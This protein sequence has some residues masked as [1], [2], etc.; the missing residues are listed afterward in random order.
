MS[1]IPC[2]VVSHA[3]VVDVNQRVFQEMRSLGDIAL[4]LAAP[5]EW[6]SDLRGHLSL[7][8][9]P[10]MEDCLL[11]MRPWLAGNGGRMHLH[12]YAKWLRVVR[13]SRPQVIFMD[14]EPYAL[15][16]LQFMLAGKAVGARMAFY[17][18]QN[19]KKRLPVPLSF[20]ERAVFALADGA[21]ALTPAVASVLRQKGFQRRIDVISHGVDLAQFSGQDVTRRRRLLGLTAPVVAYIG[22]L[23]P[24]KGVRDFLRILETLD[25]DG[26]PFSALC[27]GSG[28]LEQEVRRWRERC[29]FASRVRLLPAVPHHEVAAYYT[30]ADVVVVPSRTTPQWSE[31]FGRVLIEA[32]ACGVPVVGYDSGEIGRVLAA[33]GGGVTVI[34]G[35]VAGLTREVGRLLRSPEE[36]QA[37]GE[38]GRRAVARTFSLSAVATQLNRFLTTF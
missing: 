16:T 7:R 1:K 33:T 15:S 21:V 28:P 8:V 30:C 17:S 22:R 6:P 24:E 37:M 25:A 23:A 27:V 26:T 20:V 3:C 4:T 9:A 14:E 35:D 13:A 5:S 31:Q 12:V 36:A 29:G 11:P 18:K 32:N 38:R 2:V 19:I 10:G 34:E